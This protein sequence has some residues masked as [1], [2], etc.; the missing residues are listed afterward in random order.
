MVMMVIMIKTDCDDDAD[1]G[2]CYSK[3][4]GDEDG[5]FENWCVDGEVM[6]RLMMV[7]SKLRVLEVFVRAIELMSNLVSLTFPSSIR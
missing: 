4:D 1:A 6:M 5:I 7:M 3:D 2:R